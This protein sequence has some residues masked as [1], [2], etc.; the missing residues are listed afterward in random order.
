MATVV[1]NIQQG[2]LTIAGRTGVEW[3]RRELVDMLP[4]YE[5]IDDCIKGETTIKF[6][7]QKYLPMPNASD[8]SAENVTRYNAYL[9]RAV[10]YNVTKRTLGG[11]VGQVFL[12]EPEIKLPTKLEIMRDDATGGG[13]SLEQLAQTA[14]GYTVSKGRTGVLADYPK[15]EYE[16]TQAQIADGDVRPTLTV[17]KPQHIRNWRTLCRGGREILSLVVLEEEHIWHDDG[18]EIKTQP[19]FRVCRL[20]IPKDIA[21]AYAATNNGS[22]LDPT[23]L[24]VPLIYEVTLYQ[25]VSAD[26]QPHKDYPTYPT[27]STG[28]NLDEI[29]FTFVGVANNDPIIDEPP[30][31]DLAAINVAHYRNSADY[32]EACFIVGQP[33]PVLSGLTEHWVTNIL[34]GTVQLGSRA[35]I[36]LPVGAKAEML[37]ADPNTMPREAMEHK[38]RQMVALGAKLVEQQTV[39]RTATEAD[40]ENT[41]ETSVLASCSANVSAAF[42]WALE[43]ACRF[44]GEP[45]TSIVFKLNKDFDLSSIDA[46]A[47]AETIKEWQQGA[48][49]WEEMRAVLRKGGVATYDDDTAK[50]KIAE[51]LANAPN[52]SDNPTNINNPQNPDNINNP[53]HPDNP[54]NPKN[55]PP[56]K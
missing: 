44:V 15:L 20:I 17:Y 43:W 29:P 13:V 24:N 21:D 5:L 19:Q 6:R 50:A 38:E 26:Y 8:T 3:K 34:K 1:R 55:Q 7:K 10:F 54:A 39:Q 31:Y 9:Q 28:V 42:E 25:R 45:E 48:I 35:A 12:S 46:P 27:D 33:T 32:E 51:D 41:S 16:A 30:M 53:A 11:L 22:V 18:F 37:Q 47:R 14:V 4:L 23:S 36:P 52:L 49:M 40:I 56:A 2:A